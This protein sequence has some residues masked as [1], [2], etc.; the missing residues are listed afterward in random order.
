MTYSLHL[1]AEQDVD[2]ALN[3]TTNRQDQW[4]QRAFSK[5]SNV[6]PISWLN[7]PA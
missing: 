7:I 4:S 1:G 2:G 3:F 5:S 6:S